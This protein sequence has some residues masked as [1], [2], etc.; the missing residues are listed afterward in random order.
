MVRDAVHVLTDEKLS[1][2]LT[3]DSSIRPSSGPAVCLEMEV[4]E[5]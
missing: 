1:L 3:R 4:E 2:N 5:G